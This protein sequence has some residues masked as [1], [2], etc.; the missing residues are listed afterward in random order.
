MDPFILTKFIEPDSL[1]DVDPIVSLVVF[2][3]KDKDLIG[4]P[5]ESDDGP[6]EVSMHTLSKEIIEW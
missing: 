3:W 5:I 1:D 4:V 2:E 6:T